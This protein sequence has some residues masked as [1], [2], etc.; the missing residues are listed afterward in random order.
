M[1]PRITIAPAYDIS[2]I[3]KGG[4]HLAGDHGPIDPD[5]ALR[6]MAAFVEAGITTMDCADIYAGVE[7]RIG[8]FRIAYP[9]LSKRI[10]IHTKFVPDLPD[11]AVV[12]R[13]YVE[14]IIDRSLSRLGMERLDMVQFHWWDFAVPGYV[15]AAQELDRLR[16]VGK[17]AHVSV[18]NF[19]VPR[20]QE[21]IGAGIPICTHQLQYSLLDDRAR[22]GMADFCAAHSMTLLC[23]G[24][25]AGGFLSERW[26][27]APEPHAPLA[28]RSLVKY[29]L[30]I[31]DFGGWALFQTLLKTLAG[32][33]HAHHTDIAT[34]ATQAIL[35][36][37][38]VAAAIV[39]A[40]NASHLGA[41][42]QLADVV[43]DDAEITA[44][45]AVCSA[46]QGPLGDVYDLERDRNGRHGRIMKYELNAAP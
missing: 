12:D 24:T 46:R 1:I 30:I 2:R 22:H 35:Q 8:E 7:S 34:I 28:N 43:L 21:L 10:Q 4:W 37:P 40:T 3:I 20:L 38:T 33:A 44:I 45:D 9:E 23:Y 14:R 17:I 27:G 42:A 31:D 29:K 26:L 5:Q 18:T 25:V 41:H 19:S 11:L 39:G 16:R 6:D 13:A 32:I 36:R 15:E